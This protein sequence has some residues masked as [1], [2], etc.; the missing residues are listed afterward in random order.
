MKISLSDRAKENLRQLGQTVRLSVASGGCY[1]M[2]YT[3]DIVEKPFIQDQCFEIEGIAFC[4]PPHA[5]VYLEGIEI[6]YDNT[7]DEDEWVITKP[8]DSSPIGSCS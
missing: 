2:S 8:D 3:L 1:G 6:D 7:D 4:A 5:A